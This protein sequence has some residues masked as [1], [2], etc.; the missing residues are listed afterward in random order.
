MKGIIISEMNAR[1]IAASKTAKKS[2]P[3]KNREKWIMLKPGK[4]RKK[5]RLIGPMIRRRNTK[6]FTTE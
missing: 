3:E 6:K 1:E 4:K 2:S 5:G